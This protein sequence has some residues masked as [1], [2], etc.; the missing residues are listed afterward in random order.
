MKIIKNAIWLTGARGFADIASFLLFTV[1]SRAFGPAGT[2]EYS[3]A[4][5]VGNLVALIGS[6]GLE[7]Y[8]IREYASAVVVDRQRLWRNLV[9]TQV[10]QLM[11]AAIFL[12]LFLLS[13][14]N[15][16]ARPSVLLESVLFFIG[17]YVART[18]FVPSMALQL[19]R[20]PA[21]TDLSFRL[22]AILLAI[23]LVLFLQLSLP[24]ALIGFPAAGL[25]MAGVALFSARRLAGMPHVNAAWPALRT[26]FRGTLP[27][28]TTE[29]LNQFYA[30]AD[31]LLIAAWL[32][33]G[34]VGLYAIGVKF[35]EVG[36]LPLLL[37]GTAVYPV[38]GRL[39]RA[40]TPLLSQVTRD[41]VFLIALLTGWL[42][43]GIATLLPLLIEPVFGRD[44]SPV[45]ELLPWF[46]MFALTK[47]AEVALYRLLFCFGR[48]SWYA[49]T[50]GLGT[51]VI[52]ALN[53]VLIPKFALLGAIAAAIA[54]TAVVNIGCLYGLRGHVSLSAFASAAARVSLALALT[55]LVYLSAEDL[56]LN[57][58]LRALSCC[59]AYPLAALLVGL[60]PDWRHGPL[61]SRDMAND[62]LHG[63]TASELTTAPAIPIPLALTHNG[64]VGEKSWW[65]PELL[66]F[67]NDAIIIWEMD[68]RGILYWNHAAERMYGYTRQEA[69]GQ[70]THTLLHTRVAGVAAAEQLE[71]ALARY[72]IW[73]GEISH[74]TRAQT[75][76]NVEAR[77][78][79]LSQRNGRWLVLE[80]N[81]DLT[82]ATKTDG[83]RV[84]VEVH[85]A[86]LRK[87]Q[88]REG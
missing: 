1:I 71:T 56:S 50:L 3:Y 21:M 82:D 36:L 55:S 19:M 52:V 61:F 62:A 41:F 11:A 88:R 33:A 66:E 63:A 54:S 87:P 39:A 15:H 75:E 8:G 14:I 24:V 10:R 9:S 18:L 76:V 6:S 34:S 85:L 86:R 12:C 84:A 28:A 13:G 83:T 16:S 17:W 59:A 49:G 68:G 46:A 80:V 60:L 35:V 26:T 72:G 4:F 30:R 73:V 23:G 42:A 48:Q 25:A 57:L 43:V 53:L 74:R 58:W 37:L 29:V 79:L 81:R 32:S 40:P 5:A 44:F 65:T 27:F 77:L 2:G 51:V 7:E 67:T 45:I 69:H 78:S 31:L 38:I 22:I 20:L 47:G 64:N 70:V